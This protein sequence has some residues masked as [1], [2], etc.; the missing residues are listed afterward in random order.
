MHL[1]ENGWRNFLKICSVVLPFLIGISCISPPQ[2]EISVIQDDPLYS[3]EQLFRQHCI[4]CHSFEGAGGNSAPDL[5]EYGS[6]SW[7]IGFIQDPNASKYY[8]NTNLNKMPGYD[9]EEEDLTNL[10]A[11]LLARAD[12]DKE[13][14]PVLKETGKKILYENECYSCHTYDG[15]GGSVAPILD[16]F[17]SAKWLRGLIEDPG[18]EDFFGFRSEMPAYKGKLSKQEIDNLVY[19]LQSLRKKSH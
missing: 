6:K 3:G 16:N 9:M 2:G 19:F 17:A 5:T 1:G 10:V 12:E 7:L 8:G 13:I 18:Q 4:E 14:D 15:K 11:F